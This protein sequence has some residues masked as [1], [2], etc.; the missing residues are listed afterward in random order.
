MN[1]VVESRFAESLHRLAVGFEPLDAVLG[2]RLTHPV[3]LE[4]EGPLP[5]PPTPRGEP[6]RRA[7]VPGAPRPGADRH[8]SCLH[9]LLYQPGLGESVDVRIYDRDRRY[10]PRRLR[11]PIETLA[12]VEPEPPAQRPPTARRVR[13]PVVFLGAAYAVCERSTGLRGRV[14]RD[15]VPMRWARVEATLPGNGARVGRAHGDD[16][17]EFLLLLDPAAAPAVELTN[18]LEVRVA[19]S[20]PATAPVPAPP[21]LPAADPLWDLPLEELPP[22]GSPDPVSAGDA[23]PAGFVTSLTAT[24]I[25]DFRLGRL[26]SGDDFQFA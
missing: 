21:D 20:G 2:T 5:R 19:V 18:P 22:P 3:R 25:V 10:V 16:R 24:R 11:L 4:V 15:G 14:L 1:A 7:V 12:A 8:D 9:A 13:R 23:F 26:I 17:G 6:Y